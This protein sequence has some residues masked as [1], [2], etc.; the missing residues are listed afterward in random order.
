MREIYPTLKLYVPTNLNLEIIPEYKEKHKEKYLWFIHSI[1]FKSLTTKNDFNGYVNLQKDLLVKYLGAK[2][3][4]QIKERLITNGIIEYNKSY[5]PGAF[6]KSYRLT[7]KYRASSIKGID[8]TKQ[9]YCRKIYNSK[10]E[11]LKDVLKDNLNLKHEFR[12]LTYAKIKYDEALEYIKN[13]YD[14]TTPQYK[15]RLISLDQFNKMFN[16][17]FDLDTYL[18]DFTFLENKGRVYTPFT[19]LARDL[20][21]FIYFYGYE[22]EP[23]ITMD[24]PNSQLCFYDELIE[25]KKRIHIGSS[26]DDNNKINKR[27]IET[28]QTE[29]KPNISKKLPPITTHYHVPYVYHFSNSWSDYIFNGLGYERMMYLTRWKN[30]E[31]N[32]TKEERQEFKAEFFGQLFY[33]KYNDRL[34]DMEMVFM[35]HHEE[36]AKHLRE[37]KK[38]LGNKLLAVEVQRLES[39][40]FH[41]QIVSYLKKHYP[42]I[43]FIIKHDSISVPMSS[44]S[45]LAIELNELVKMFFR[46]NNLE[47]K[48]S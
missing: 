41:K 30:K 18:I 45:Y 8:I 6:S 7:N 35:E 38:E 15:S 3:Y 46:C 40:F 27:I 20:E 32:H 39:D 10:S 9:T 2:F 25:R 16:T 17:S 36:T 37:L 4:T 21:Q 31:I 24:M 13:K 19:M 5:S 1:L 22:D 14:E 11:Y 44:A 47:L 42:N 48:V 12:A 43:P 34:T 33:N 23:V 28:P 26:I 29:K